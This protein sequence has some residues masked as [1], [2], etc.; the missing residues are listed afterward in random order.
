MHYFA[1]LEELTRLLPQVAT[2]QDDWLCAH[3]DN[4][5][6]HPQIS[7]TCLFEAD[8]D[9]DWVKDVC[10]RLG[11]HAILPVK[12]ALDCLHGSPADRADALKACVMLYWIG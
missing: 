4:W 5:L 6:G 1:N 8:D 12:D 10:G 3:M 11:L 2:D 7:E 9:P